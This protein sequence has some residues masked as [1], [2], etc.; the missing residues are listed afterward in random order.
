[1]RFQK[2][3]LCL[4][5]DFYGFILFGICLVSWNCGFMSFAKFG[6]FQALFLWVL[7]NLP[8]FP[9]PSGTPKTQMIDLLWWFHKS[10]KLCLLSFCFVLLSLMF[11]LC[12]FYYSISL[13]TD[14]FFCYLHPAVD[15]IYWVFY[16]GFWIFSSKISILFFFIS[17]IIFFFFWNCIFSLC[18]KHN[19][20]LKLFYDGC[21]SS[22]CR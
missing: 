9:S 5:V 6:S 1:M 15:T 14:S 7:F 10:L 3:D 13:F 18:F 20:S 2:F 22:H 4:G 12:T 11:R 21:F 19:W 8:S 17:S 16:F